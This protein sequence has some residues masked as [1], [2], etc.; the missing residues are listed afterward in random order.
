M[1]LITKI[2]FILALTSCA[3]QAKYSDEV[4]YDIA[5]LLKDVGVAVDGE[6]KFGNTA[7]LTKDEIIT[8]A[9]SSNPEQLT[10]LVELA[11]EGDI[12]DYRMISEFQGDNVVM[13][14]C[15]GEVALMEDAGCNAAFDNP[16]WDNP[17]PNSCTITLNAAQVCSN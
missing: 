14:I 6:L 16:Y 3:T 15:D 10:R 1:R 13:M 2:A 5:S 7:N 17:Q 9:T 11:K 8:N 4:M 12:T